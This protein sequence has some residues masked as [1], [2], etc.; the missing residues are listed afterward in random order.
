MTQVYRRACR[1]MTDTITRVGRLANE[2]SERV[3]VT[4]L[5]EIRS[6]NRKWGAW[7]PS[8][9]FGWKDLC[10][11]VMRLPENWGERSDEIEELEPTHGLLRSGWTS[12]STWAERLRLSR[13]AHCRWSFCFRYSVRALGLWQYRWYMVTR[14]W[15]I[16]QAYKVFQGS[17]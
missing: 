3:T 12:G 6:A 2:T 14:A 5:R 9:L 16:S 11:Q 1:G 10:N 8:I 17:L 4:W 15:E 7:W 13:F